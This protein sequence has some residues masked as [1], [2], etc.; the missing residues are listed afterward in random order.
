MSVRDWVIKVLKQTP[1]GMRRKEILR[2]IPYSSLP[3]VNEVV[4]QL[5][6]EGLVRY[7][8]RGPFGEASYVIWT[9]EKTDG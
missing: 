2:K 3:R 7:S 6:E 1:Y 8:L 4:K 5:H 9:G